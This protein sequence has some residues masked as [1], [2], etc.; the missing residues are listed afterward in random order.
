MDFKSLLNVASRFKKKPLAGQ[1]VPTG[2]KPVAPKSVSLDDVSFYVMPSAAVGGAGA[3]VAPAATKRTGIIIIA[4]GGVVLVAAAGALIWYIFLAGPSAPQAG[5][6]L[7]N[8][9]AAALPAETPGGLVPAATSTSSAEEELK[10]T[11]D[12]LTEIAC[13]TAASSGDTAAWACLGERL[14]AGCLPARL[15]VATAA[16]TDT[17]FTVQGSRSGRCVVELAYPS[18]TAV[19]DSELTPYAGT[20]LQCSYEV[21]MD[22]AV[23]AAQAAYAATVPLGL[24]TDH[25]CSGTAV[26]VWEE[27]IAEKLAANT[28]LGTD[29]DEDG[30]TDVEEQTVYATASDAADT[31]S[32]GYDDGVEVGNGYNPAGLGNL[33]ESGLMVA[34][35]NE[36]PAY[37]LTHPAAWSVQTQA[38]GQTVLITAP[39]GGFFQVVAHRNDSGVSLVEWYRT[40][41]GED[42]NISAVTTTANGFSYLVSGDGLTVY[43]MFAAD[44]MTVLVATY[45]PDDGRVE[46]QATFDLMV[47]S[48]KQ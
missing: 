20:S 12:D 16:G 27:R 46:Y 11:A 43:G 41:V 7:A 25:R 6:P 17:V 31:D 38:A 33:V 24:A 36:T 26:R 15:T 45:S 13:G 40:T 4:T 18:A 44:P 14:Q 1:P 37:R 28:V 48:L 32:D 23:L 8:I 47:R 10:E 9:P 2:T 30:L 39:T 34:F 19:Y 5:A 29:S 42:E 3:V 21:G 22:S 35:A